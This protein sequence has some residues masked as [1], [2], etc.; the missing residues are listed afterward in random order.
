MLNDGFEIGVKQLSNLE[1]RNSTKLMGII[2]FKRVYSDK[3]LIML[4]IDM[5]LFLRLMKIL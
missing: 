3:E 2:S 5:V 4:S 1:K